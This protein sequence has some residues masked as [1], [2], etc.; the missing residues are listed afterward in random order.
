MLLIYKVST[1]HTK[2]TIEMDYNSI[3]LKLQIYFQKQRYV[4]AS[5]SNSVF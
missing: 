3:Y 2:I 4:D 5:L 1:S